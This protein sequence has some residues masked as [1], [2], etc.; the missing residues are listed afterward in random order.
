MNDYFYD[1][2]GCK[3]QIKVTASGRINIIGE[4]VDYCGGP[5][6]PASL[7]LKCNVY[8][9]ANGCGKIRIALYGIEGVKEL[10]LNSLESYRDAKYINYQAGVAFIL[11]SQGYNLV[12]CDLYY[13]CDVP[14]GS[15]LSSSAAIEVAT[16]VALNEIAKN[17]YSLEDMALIGQ[18]AENEYCGMN[19]GIMDQFAS[20]IGKKDSAVLL[21]CD[22]LE[23][24]YVP[25]KMDG[26]T[27]VVANSNKRHTL[28][29]GD[30]N[31]RRAEAEK[32]TEILKTV[33]PITRL[34]DLSVERFEEAK[35]VL[36][37]KILDRATHVVNECDRVYKAVA[38]LKRGDIA[39]LGQ[40]INASHESLSTLY[41]VTG[42]ELDCLAHIAQRQKG[43]LGSRMIG[44]GFGGCT[45]S[46]V[47]DGEVENF[48]KTVGEQ[49]EK[50]VGYK[51][52]FYNTSIED[53]VTVEEL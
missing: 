18:R 9:R 15:G 4:H 50:A 48:I 49:Y 17:S 38:A 52:T 13:K 34:A 7:N 36:S 5:V 29:D 12:G 10:D 39:T 28:T 46:I 42:Y 43:C 8:G 27:M 37:G 33:T 16:A 45:I 23:Y 31:E 21:H 22:T 11:K 6:F 1:I 30:Y 26:Y 40:L 24:E 32:A 14:F 20:A 3:P 2:Y 19:C 53:G 47:E 44:G 25:L 35:G 41:E 51:A